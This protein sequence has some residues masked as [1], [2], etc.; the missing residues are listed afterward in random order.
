MESVGGLCPSQTTDRAQLAHTDSV[1]PLTHSITAEATTMTASEDN[2]LPLGQAI[3]LYPKF[4]GYCLALVIVVVGY[5]YDLTIVGSMIGVESFQ[6]DYG[7]TFEGRL[8]IPASWLAAWQAA[9]PLGMAFGSL[10]GGWLQDRIGRKLSLMI[11]SVIVAVGVT[12][13]FLSYLP[14]NRDSVRAMFFVGKLIQGF[15]VGILK[16]TA[17]TYISENAPTSMRG[18]AMGLFPAANLC[19]QL[20]GAIVTYVVNN[21][22]GR[23][24]YLGAFGSQ[25]GLAVAPFILSL[26]I[27]ESPSYL[28]VKGENEKA[29]AMAHRLFAPRVDPR[30]SL[31]AMKASI[32]EDRLLTRD[33]SYIGCFNA[34]NRRRTGI[35]IMANLYPALFGLELIARASYFLQL[36]GMKSSTSLLLLI[37]GVVAG[38]VANGIG[39]WFLSQFGRRRLAITS[40]LGATV[41]WAAIGIA[42]IWSTMAVA[43]FV[44]V[45]LLLTIIVCGMGVWGTS[46]AIMGEV[47]SLAMRAKT[48]AL[49]SVVQQGSSAVMSVILPY[50]YNPDAG[51]LKAKSGFIYVGTCALAVGLTWLIVPEMKGRTVGEIDQMFSQNVPVR[52]FKKWKAADESA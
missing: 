33:A 30:I 50:A 16:V 1:S 49:G 12:I 40:L 25:W 19:G 9:T 26:F 7:S 3:E 28:L 31:Q 46:Y 38:I 23:V 36:L 21:V 52:E 41:L 32:E 18:S 4:V 34:T 35:A 5:G 51:D 2:A 8:I 14:P 42:G 48:Q 29:A 44:A 20:C 45:A 6:R 11:G 15:A 47:S 37:G 39:I 10:F 43:Y 24:G 13:I 17:M 22:E 27:P